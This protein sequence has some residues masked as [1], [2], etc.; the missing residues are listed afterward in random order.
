MITHLKN[1]EELFE[2]LDQENEKFVV[3]VRSDAKTIEMK[4][5][6]E[7]IIEND[8]LKVNGEIIHIGKLFYPQSRK[9]RS[10]MT[11]WS[12]EEVE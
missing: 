11:V 6:A 10:T 2:T 7:G 4:V 5:R 8:V 12:I 1:V 9:T 3:G